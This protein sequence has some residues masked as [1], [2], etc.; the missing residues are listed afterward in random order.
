MAGGVLLFEK[1]DT[2]AALTA[3]SPARIEEAVLAHIESTV[4]PL[5]TWEEQGSVFVLTNFLA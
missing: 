3:D 4:C 5:V 2:Q 1:R